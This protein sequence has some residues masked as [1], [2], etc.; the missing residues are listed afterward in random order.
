M[1]RPN[2][3]LGILKQYGGLYEAMMRTRRRSHKT[4]QSFLQK[5]F[6]L[7]ELI[8][9]MAVVGILAAVSAPS[10][11]SMLDSMKIDQTV[12][13]LRISLQD[14]QRQAIRTSQMCVVQIPANQGESPNSSPLPQWLVDLLAQLRPSST[15]NKKSVTGNC[16]TSG[17]PEIP[18]NVDLASNVQAVQSVPTS[19]PSSGS[20]VIQ[21]NS[22]GSADFSISS[23]V[24]S[25]ALPVDPTGKVVAFIPANLQI[26]KKCVAISSTLGLTRVGTYTGN[27]SPSDITDQGVCT[28]LDWKNQ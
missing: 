11:A 1:L 14:T 25:P 16:L 20:V 5:G 3:I 26:K 4:R 17:S 6:T 27:I 2:L 22:L 10:F 12:N 24:T 28:A 9:I 8:I 13:E 21:F 7:L 19:T 18:S 23:A 15:P